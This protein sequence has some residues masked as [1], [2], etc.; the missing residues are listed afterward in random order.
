VLPAAQLRRQLGQRRGELG[1]LVIAAA[2]TNWAGVVASDLAI[3]SAVINT[4]ATAPPASAMPGQVTPW[5]KPS[6]SRSVTTGNIIPT[7]RRPDK[8]IPTNSS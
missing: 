2:R 3:S 8:F 4:T 6:V 1:G 7:A 5:M